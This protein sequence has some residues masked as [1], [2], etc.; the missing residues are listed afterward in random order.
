[1]AAVLVQLL[2]LIL[3]AV[4]AP[5]WIIIVLLLLASPQGL[6][7]ATAFVLGMTLIRAL[8]GLIFGY[9][10]GASP[11]NAPDSGGSSPIV[12]TLLLVVG[13][14]LL[15]M[16][17]LKWR[18]ADD[19]DEPPPKWMQSFESISPL[20]ALGLGALFVGIGVKLWVFTLSALSII[21]GAEL[22][23]SAGVLAYL[24]YMV[25]AQ[26]ALIAAI[27]VYAV[28]PTA[29]GLLT[30]ALDW[31]TRYNRPISIA[32]GLIFGTY[33]GYQGIRGLLS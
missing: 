8:Q 23:R 28:V 18:K 10:F 1:M 27:V 31:L 4:L 26:G 16:A 30:R 22:G 11:D 2:P 19:P 33:F 6:L 17:Y 20:H 5:I 15:I 14:L 9:V 24:I 3:G 32:V 13:I 12:S 21:S 25:L 7:K 29:A